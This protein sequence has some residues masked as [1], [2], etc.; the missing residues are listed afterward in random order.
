MEK[1]SADVC[2]VGGGPAGMVLGL[3][4]ARKGFRTLVLEQHQDFA[5]EYRGEVLMPRFTQLF[6]KIGLDDWLLTLP[7]LKLE[8]GELLF[9][10]KRIGRLDF[11]LMAP[12]VPYALWMPQPVLLQ[13]LYELTKKYS[14]CEVWFGASVQQLIGDD[15]VEGCV[16][17]RGDG[18]TQVNARVVVGADGRY[19]TVLKQ[20]KFTFEYEDHKFDLIWFTIPKPKDYDNT[21][22]VLFSPRKSFLLLPKHPDAIQVGILMKKGGLQE[23]MKE[24]ID[25]VREEISLAHPLFVDFAKTLKDFSVFHPLQAHLHFVKDWAKNGCLL[26]GD[27][28]HCCSPAGAIGVSM[29]VG[30][31]WVAGEVIAKGLQSSKGI[32]TRTVLSQVQKQVQA[33]VRNVHRIQRLLT[34]GGLGRFVP[35]RW[36][37]PLTVTLV[38]RTPLFRRLQRQLMTL[39]S[40][41][42][43]ILVGL[44]GGTGNWCK[45]MICLLG[46]S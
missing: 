38:A 22:R 11:R 39:P 1:T 16:I 34:G 31:A 33:D 25:Q 10:G 9:A 32:L 28:A 36:L 44:I 20:G 6:R 26:I 5:R 21:F 43:P 4:L 35:I 37:L 13:G 8:F 29:A 40:S 42:W 24:G 3:L 14:N 12:D 2:I 18:M 15:P 41:N 19:S 23:L 30:T 7:H 46:L 45:G 27:A 17:R